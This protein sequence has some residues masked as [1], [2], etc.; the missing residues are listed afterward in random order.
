MENSLPVA[1]FCDGAV[2]CE[3]RAQ[4]SK[5]IFK[6]IK[7]QNYWKNS[8]NVKCYTCAESLQQGFTY[9]HWRTNI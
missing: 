6:K 1:N 2:K 7:T 8:K 5:I 9:V 3:I 4:F